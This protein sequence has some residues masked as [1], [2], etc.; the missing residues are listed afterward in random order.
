MFE[1]VIQGLL[2]ERIPLFS[3]CRIFI[4]ASICKR[5][6]EEFG[7]CKALIDSSLRLNPKYDFG[8]KIAQKYEMEIRNLSDIPKKDRPLFKKSLELDELRAQ[9]LYRKTVFQKY[10]KFL[11][12]YRISLSFATKTTPTT[13]INGKQQ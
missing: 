9:R 1:N 7:A 2:D 13:Y 5:Y 6:L 10:E 11:D 12:D 8:W 3:A 4:N